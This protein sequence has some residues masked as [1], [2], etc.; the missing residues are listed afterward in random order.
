MHQWI[1][2]SLWV[3][4]TIFVSYLFLLQIYIGSVFAADIIATIQTGLFVPHNPVNLA[5]TIGDTEVTL[6][7]SP[8]L[9]NGGVAITDY[10]IEYKLSSG[11]VWVVY[12]DGSSDNTTAD[13]LGLANDTSYD[14]RVSAV[15][16]IGQ[17]P[18]S[19]IISGTPGSP[20]QV[21]ITGFT[22]LTVPSIVATARITN[23]G[24]A[25]YEYQYT[26]CV[27]TSDSNLCGGGDDVMSASAAKL[28]QSGENW[29]TALPAIVVSAGNYW[30]HL[31]V[32]FGSDTSYASQ[33]FTASAPVSSGGGGGGGGGSGGGG[34][35][36]RQCIGGDMNRD[37]KVNLIDF[38]IMLTFFSK[39]P[40]FKNKCVDINQDGAV[41]VVDFSILLTQWEKKPVKFVK[42]K[43]S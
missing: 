34:S 31:A 18:A 33:S 20:A 1:K 27:T 36:T 16:P 3:F 8:P 38:S 35:S 15:N 26:W 23:E 17:G 24:A 25:A 41:T 19:S 43:S 28:I 29:D 12:G 37:N 2:K 6:S 9:S 7:W 21:L 11:G 14:F 39:S 40:P 22:N 5:I 42:V 13:V 32:H 4:G 10:V 30:F